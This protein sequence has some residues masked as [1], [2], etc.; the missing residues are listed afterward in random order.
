MGKSK[1]LVEVVV[2]NLFKRLCYD[3]N[4]LFLFEKR[5]FDLHNNQNGSL[6]S[7]KE[8]WRRMLTVLKLNRLAE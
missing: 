1:L 5:N 8:N 4:F 2:N 7:E 3:N 6:S